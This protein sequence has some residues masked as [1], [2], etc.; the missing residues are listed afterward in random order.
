MS[1]NVVV[2]FQRGTAKNKHYINIYD[3]LYR[4]G[5]NLY[6]FLGKTVIIERLHGN[7]CIFVL[8]HL[9]KRRVNI[10]S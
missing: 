5:R 7:F 4:C 3:T 1:H 6:N 10:M 2:D 9:F 8:F